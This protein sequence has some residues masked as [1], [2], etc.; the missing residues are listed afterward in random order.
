LAWVV[1]KVIMMIGFS[2]VKLI[3]FGNFGDDGLGKSGLGRVPG[4]LGRFHLVVIGAENNGSVLGPDIVALL[5]QGGWIMEFPKPVEDIFIR[6]YLR[7][8]LHFHYLGMS[9]RSRADLL[10]GGIRF[11]SSRI[12][13]LN[14]QDALNPLV[15]RLQAPEATTS[16]DSGFRVQLCL[17]SGEATVQSLGRKTLSVQPHDQFQS[18]ERCRSEDPAL[19]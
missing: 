16:D 1:I 10:V 15:K 13:R 11:H 7:V 4:T 18:A 12:A 14:R 6:N 2:R 3:Q 17:L 8:V 9:G 5:V 19:F